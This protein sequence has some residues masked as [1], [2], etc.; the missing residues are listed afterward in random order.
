MEEMGD[1]VHEEMVMGINC[2]RGRCRVG[3]FG[4]RRFRSRLFN[5]L[6]LVLDVMLFTGTN[7]HILRIGILRIVVAQVPIRVSII[8]G[9]SRESHGTWPNGEIN[10]QNGGNRDF[11]FDCPAFF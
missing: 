1:V 4:T 9:R 7:G 8:V 2:C 11:Q 3:S 5:F 10:C 6:S